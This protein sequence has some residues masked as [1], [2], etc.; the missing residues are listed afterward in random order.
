MKQISSQFRQHFSQNNLKNIWNRKG[1]GSIESLNK[2][3]NIFEKRFASF[4]K[5]YTC[6]NFCKKNLMI[7]DFYLQRRN[8]FILTQKRRRADI[9]RPSN[10]DKSKALH[11]NFESQGRNS[12]F[13]E[14]LR[15]CRSEEIKGNYKSL[16]KLSIQLLE[17]EEI[18]S[19][20]K[21][22]TPLT[23]IC[24]GSYEF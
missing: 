8:K 19:S 7:D 21:S 14:I 24:S 22:L 1:K 5:S 12:Q 6:S 13:H 4:S 16:Q 17:N 20:E 23:P 9:N 15:S 18:F 2:I 11:K 3:K 10:E